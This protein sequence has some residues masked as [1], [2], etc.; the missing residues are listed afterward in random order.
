MVIAAHVSGYGPGRE[1]NPEVETWVPACA[2]MTECNMVI[3]AHVSGYGAGRER[4]PEV[5]TWVPACA[6]MTECSMVIPAK[7]SYG[8]GNGGPCAVG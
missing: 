1:R 8:R 6:G 4:N 5:E 7:V 3:A 2:G